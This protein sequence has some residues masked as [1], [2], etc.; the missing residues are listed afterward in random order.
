MEQHRLTRPK[1]IK[2]LWLAFAAVLVATVLAEIWI[3][4]T[5]HFDVERHFAFNAI[6][7]F[8]ACAAMI[9][10]SRGLGLML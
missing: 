3:P 2:R 6:L 8:L 9:L 7:G 4:T 10:V 1:S 5:P